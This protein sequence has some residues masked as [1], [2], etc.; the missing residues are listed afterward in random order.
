MTV[1]IGGMAN[2]ATSE[3]WI[4][5]QAHTKSASLTGRG[6]GVNTAEI[7]IRMIAESRDAVLVAAAAVVVEAESAC[8]QHIDPPNR[9]Y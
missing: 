7:K 6:T 2:G 9:R 4:V 1:H 8:R 5:P 3:V